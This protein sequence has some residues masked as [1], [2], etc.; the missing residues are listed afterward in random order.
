ME[1]PSPIWAKLT[2]KMCRNVTSQATL[3]PRGHNEYPKC[4]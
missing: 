3:P 1:S 2:N 4:V